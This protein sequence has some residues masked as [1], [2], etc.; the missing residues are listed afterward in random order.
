MKNKITWGLKNIAPAVII[1]VSI[2]VLWKTKVLPPPWY[3][4]LIAAIAIL[5][6][7]GLLR[8]LWAFPKWQVKQL[9]KT[10]ALIKTN[11][12]F[13]LENK[14]RK[15]IA[16]LIIFVN[17]SRGLPSVTG[18]CRRIIGTHL[19]NISCWRAVRN[20]YHAIRQPSAF[21]PC[22]QINASRMPIT[23]HSL[24]TT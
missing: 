2:L 6:L 4:T 1:V 14:A 22:P 20:S 8:I 11:E 12:L 15:T 9:Q 13:S 16:Q 18:R 7:A 24:P 5:S 23:W 3:Y 21:S 17:T 10:K 19:S